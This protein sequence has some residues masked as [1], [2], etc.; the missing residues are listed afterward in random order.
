MKTRNKEANCG[1]CPYWDPIEF[2]EREHVFPTGECRRFPPECLLVDEA[3]DCCELNP[4][5]W[6]GPRQWD[7]FFCG[8]HPDFFVEENDK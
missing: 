4:L 6:T 3:A 2:D 7:S 5:S 8:E 1:N